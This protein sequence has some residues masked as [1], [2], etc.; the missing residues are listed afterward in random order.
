MFLRPEVAALFARWKE[1]GLTAAVA[2]AGLWVAFW[3]GWF[4]AMLGGLVAVTGFG[5]GLVAV[6]RVRFGQGGLDPG[7]V[8]ITEGQLAY[9]GPFGGGFVGLTDLAELALIRSGGARF[10]RLTP[11]EG[12]PLMVPVAALGA[13]AL[14]DAFAGLPGLDSRA[15]VAVLAPEAQGDRILWTRVERVGRG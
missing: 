7:V 8:R 3:G 4:F 5:L 9:L 6:R 2:L 14:F 13:E 11:T 1:V 12:V 15:L 10:W